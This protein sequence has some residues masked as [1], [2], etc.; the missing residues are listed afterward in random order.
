MCVS[1]LELPLSRYGRRDMVTLYEAGVDKTRESCRSKIGTGI[2]VIGL[3]R[4]GGV[5]LFVMS[6]TLFVCALIPFYTC[7]QH[8]IV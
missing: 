8:S 4:L 2:F 3:L 1:M 7:S 6:R 5:D